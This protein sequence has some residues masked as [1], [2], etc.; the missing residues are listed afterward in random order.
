MWSRLRSAKLPLHSVHWL[1]APKLQNKSS[2]PSERVFPRKTKLTDEEFINRITLLGVRHRIVDKTQGFIIRCSNCTMQFLRQDFCH[3]LAN[4]PCIP[5]VPVPRWSGLLKVASG[6]NGVSRVLIAAVSTDRTGLLPESQSERPK[7]ALRALADDEPAPILGAAKR[8][9]L[10]GSS[11]VSIQSVP[12]LL[13]E[14]P[15]VGRKRLH[16]SHRLE[17]C[18][19]IILCT[20]CGYFF[21]DHGQRAHPNFVQG[22]LRSILGCTLIDG[23][24]V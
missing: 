23:P 19:G 20:R 22:I 8:R 3:V 7:R 18:K 16:R 2:V 21:C 5:I 1:K 15:V 9:I 13:A 10:S 17:H 11:A 6:S 12:P 4:G 14:P 24:R